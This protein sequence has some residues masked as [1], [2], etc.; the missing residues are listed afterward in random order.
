MT[1]NI[2]LDS[3]HTLLATYQSAIARLETGMTGAISDALTK[4]ISLILDHDGHLV[5]CGMGKSGLV[6][7]KIAATL[8]STGT[9]ALFLHPAE[10][11]HGDLGVVRDNDVIILISNSGETEEVVKLLPALKRLNV[12]IISLIGRA[13]SSLGKAADVILDASVDKEACP[14]N[15]APTTSSMAALVL[16][17]ALAVVLMEHRGFKA[18]DFAARHP[19]G[20][21]GQTLLN[22]VSDKMISDNLPF[23]PADMKMSEVIVEMTRCRLGL[24]LVGSADALQGI[25]TDGDLRRMLVEARAL[26]EATAA[27]IMSASPQ[28]IAKTANLGE[29]EDKMEKA[30]LQSL[31]VRQTQDSSSPVCGIIQIF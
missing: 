20:K 23:V 2:S 6:G 12:K 26:D 27:D 30:K 19:G 18:E 4:A 17:D 14:L 9:P 8:S 11:I 5:I 3:A 28:F 22:N 7:R 31:V 29:A 1:H 25:I 24:A 10:A 21:L 13:D 15:L 16:G